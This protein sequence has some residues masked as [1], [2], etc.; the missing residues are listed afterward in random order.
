MRF[1]SIL[2]FASILSILPA[3]A[4]TAWKFDFGSG[5]PAP[6]HVAVK[7]GDRFDP[8]NG[9]GFDLAGKP[10]DGPG[11][12]TGSG[13]FYFSMTAPEGNY[14]VTLTLGDPAAE[15]GT[16]VKAESRQLML[17]SIK[18]PAGKP[19]VHRFTAH[20]RQPAI[21]GGSA[22]RLKDR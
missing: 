6:G 10:V 5:E 13:G 22:V 1:P 14:E 8:A 3:A 7:A 16:T 2:S 19:V 9:H 20:V 12:V 4:E 11:H 21:P 18:T 15:S 17:E